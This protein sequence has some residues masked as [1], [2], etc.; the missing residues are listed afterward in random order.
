MNI[1]KKGIK[2]L[3][4]CNVFIFLTAFSYSQ[5]ISNGQFILQ[6]GRMYYKRGNSKAF[7][8]QEIDGKLYYFGLDGEM[9]RGWQFIPRPVKH[10]TLGIFEDSSN[11][12]ESFPVSEWFYFESDGSL[13]MKTGFQFV[14]E[15]TSQTIG[16]KYGETYPNTAAKSLYYFNDTLKYPSLKTGWIKNMNKWY[17]FKE[18]SDTNSEVDI[19]LGKLQ[20]GWLMYNENWYF[21]DHNNGSMKTG[22]IFSEGKWYYLSSSGAMNTGWLWRNNSWYYLNK[23]GEM[24]VSWIKIHH[25]WYYLDPLY[26]QMKTGWYQVGNDWYYSYSSGELAVSTTINGYRLNANGAWVK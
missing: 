23:S 18:T 7:Y 11:I 1:W 13:S 17:Y 2:Y 21:L 25:S 8:W 24:A 3:I 16:K 12:L 9:V 6:N 22:W 26:G 20:T 19:E 4:L 14:E 10:S 5:N 15:K